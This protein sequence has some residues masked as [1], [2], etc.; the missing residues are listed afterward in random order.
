MHKSLVASLFVAGTLLFAATGQAQNRS[1]APRRS[2]TFAGSAAQPLASASQSGLASQIASFLAQRGIFVPADSVVVGSSSRSTNGQLIY[3]LEQQ[4]GGLRVY[5]VS[6]KAATNTNGD[7]VFLTQNFTAVA[8]TPQG[9]AGNEEQALRAALNGLYPGQAI[10]VGA[11]RREANSVVFEKTPFFFASPRV[12]HVLFQDEDGSLNRGLLVETWS[13]KGNLL[14]ETL[15]G[16]GGNVL[17]VVPRT[18]TDSYNV[19][20][21]DPLKDAQTVVNGAVIGST[22]SPSGW[23]AGS[24]TTTHIVGNNTDTYLDADNNNAADGGGTAVVDGNFTTAVDLGAAPTTT[25]NKA[26]AVQN[27]FYLTNVMHDDLYKYGFNEGN[28]NFQTNNFT[29]GGKGNDPV[30]AEAQDGGG[31]DNANFSTPSDGSKPRMQMYLWTGNGP[32]HEV[33]AG[34]TYPAAGAD[35]GGVL[36]TAGTTA[37]LAVMAP[38]DGCTTATASLTGKIAIIDRGTC[39]FDQK[40]KNAQSAGAVAAIVANNAGDDYFTM[41][42]AQRSGSQSRP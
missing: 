4:V 40:V 2:Q 18:A 32:T 1:F 31:T 5:G 16:G 28:G 37:L 19:F 9:A 27:L 38:A 30:L 13:N 17:D 34:S 36:N 42:P 24:Q 7:L 11:A 26:V 25:G 41:G 33:V 29:S 14:H 3:R 15:V 22:V 23:L 20:V 10:A 35:F 39:N 8:G 21:E 12:S 6:A